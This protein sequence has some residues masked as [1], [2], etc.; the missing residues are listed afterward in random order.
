MSNFD[1]TPSTI[2]VLEEMNKTIAVLDHTFPT[3]FGG[4]MEVI[5][6]LTRVIPAHYASLEHLIFLLSK[7][8]YFQI[9]ENWQLE[10]GSDMKFGE[11]QFKVPATEEV[12]TRLKS[13]FSVEHEFY[14]FCKKRLDRQYKSLVLAR[15]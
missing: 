8:H 3:I 9:Y 15:H 1:S 7:L 11:N 13:N 12:M 2:L 14:E 4:V 5:F 10:K 6:L